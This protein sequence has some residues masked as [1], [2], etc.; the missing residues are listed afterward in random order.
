M[1][2]YT[3]PPTGGGGGGGGGG[4]EQQGQFAPGPQTVLNLFG[5]KYD[6]RV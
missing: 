3:V 6:E 4:G 2:R 5:F 1:L